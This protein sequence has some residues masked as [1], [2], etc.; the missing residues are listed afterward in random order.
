[1]SRVKVIQAEA[2]TNLIT[3]PSLER[4]TTDWQSSGLATF[5][6][7]A[8]WSARG[9]WSAHGIANSIGDYL[10][11]PAATTIATDYRGTAYV[12][13]VSGSWRVRR[14]STATGA[15]DITEAGEQRAEIGWAGSAGTERLRFECLSAAGEI[16]VDAVQ[17]EAKSGY[18][19]SY[20]DG[21]QDEGIWAG[22]AHASTSSR[23]SRERTGGRVVDL[24]DELGLLYADI[25]GVGVPTLSHISQPLAARDG[26][27]LQRVRANPA[28]ISLRATLRA[29]TLPA[30]HTVRRGLVDLLRPTPLQDFAPLRFLYSGSGDEYA[31]DAHYLAGLEGSIPRPSNRERIDLQFVAYDPFWQTAGDVGASLDTGNTISAN[32][33]VRRRDGIWEALSTGADNDINAVLVGRDG[34]IYVTGTFLNIGGIAATRI[35]YFDPADNAWHAMGTGLNAEGFTLAEGPDGS[36]YAGGDFTLAGGVANTVRV[37]K[38]NGSAWSALSTGMNGFVLV[39]RFGYDGRLWAGG[40]FTTAGGSSRLGIAAWNGT[41]WQSLSVDFISGAS[42]GVF[43]IAFAPNGDAYVV[44]NFTTAAGADHDFM[45]KYDGAT[46]TETAAA[47]GGG[48]LFPADIAWGPDGSAYLAGSFVGFL[49][50]WNGQQFVTLSSGVNNTVNDF[51][52]DTAGD[53]YLGGAFTAAGSLSLSD[54]VAK[55][56]GSAFVPLPIDLP[57][58]SSVA[59]VYAAGDD[60]Y[61][62]GDFSGSAT[63]AAETAVVNPGSAD[64][65]PVIRITGPAT[66]RSIENLTTK[67]ELV[68]D[69]LAV[70]TDEIITLDLRPG[71]KTARSS[72]RGNVASAIL[73]GSDFASFA[74]EPGSN[75]IAVLAN[76]GSADLYFRPRHW[77]A[78]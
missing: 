69:S 57:G 5:E 11:T 33:I 46:W 49:N 34:K 35:A 61:I 39:L 29:A 54:R 15:V 9:A 42:T 50:R 19:T 24:M 56:N 36:I 73:A 10:E 28:V 16:Y 6:R 3:N 53:L 62:A 55:W 43:D 45:A 30:L 70:A 23:S 13:V 17:I 27:I 71:R 37:A 51:A 32:R 76:G 64:A 66:L 77:G 38:W 74:L 18:A 65:F 68:F 41:T 8:A 63:V 1:M 47:P 12:N 48:G 78:E 26:A 44:G 21:D 40:F 31:I 59:A 20:V 75:R 72:L 52:W 2:T 25:H 60:L 4:A 58:S 7:S 22:I 67:Q 14:A